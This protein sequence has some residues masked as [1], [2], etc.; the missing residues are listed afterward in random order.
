M[1]TFFGEM[2][3]YGAARGIFVTTFRFTAAARDFAR[4]HGIDLM[5]GTALVREDLVR[6]GVAGNHENS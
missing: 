5:D 2:L 4:Q 3:H 6:P 1:R